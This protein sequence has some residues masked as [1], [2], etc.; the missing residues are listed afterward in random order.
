M[1][2]FCFLPCFQLFESTSQGVQ[3]YKIMSHL[4]EESQKVYV[5]KA[6]SC[7]KNKGQKDGK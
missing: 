3:N 6:T 2:V 1:P 7:T 4:Q 5:V